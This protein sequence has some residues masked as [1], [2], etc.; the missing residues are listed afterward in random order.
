MCFASDIIQLRHASTNKVSPSLLLTK[1]LNKQLRLSVL[2]VVYF[3]H[4]NH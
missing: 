1:L 4:D 3:A 2:M